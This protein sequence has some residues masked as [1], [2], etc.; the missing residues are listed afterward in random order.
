MTSITSCSPRTGTL[1]TLPCFCRSGCAVATT[2]PLVGPPGG[3]RWHS[4]SLSSSARGSRF[5]RLHLRPSPVQAGSLVARMRD[6]EGHDVGSARIQSRPASSSPAKR[7]KR[8]SVWEQS[9]RTRANSGAPESVGCLKE[10]QAEPT[11]RTD[12]GRLVMKKFGPSAKACSGIRRRVPVLPKRVFSSQRFAIL[13]RSVMEAMQDPVVAA[14]RL[15]RVLKLSIRSIPENV[16]RARS[17]KRAK[18]PS[19]EM[20]AVLVPREAQPL[21]RLGLSAFLCSHSYA[22]D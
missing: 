1:T 20:A 22:A 17:T 9:M 14:H 19:K 7:T 15:F 6:C 8:G 2:I 16:G 18:L 10:A 4:T 12:R 13:S 3:H 11:P 21:A 5:R